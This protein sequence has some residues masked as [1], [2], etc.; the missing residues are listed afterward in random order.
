MDQEFDKRKP[1]DEAASRYEAVKGTPLNGAINWE[2]KMG[3]LIPICM[4]AAAVICAVT[5]PR[6]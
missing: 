4:I 5:L 6:L 2:V 1:F 3:F